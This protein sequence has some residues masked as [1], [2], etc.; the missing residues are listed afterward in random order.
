[1]VKKQES[2]FLCEACGLG[3]REKSIAQKCEDWCT[4]RHSCNLEI[5]KNAVKA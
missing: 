5:I 4:A 3:Y 1:M 2:L